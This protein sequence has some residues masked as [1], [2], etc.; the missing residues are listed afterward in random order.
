MDITV[1]ILIIVI[2]VIAYVSW[3][4]DQ[5]RRE[6]YQIWAELHG[7]SYDYGRDRKVYHHYSNFTR[8]QQGSNRY[9]FDI[10]RG[11]LNEYPA[12][13]FNFHYETY[14]NTS[15]GRRTTHHH[16]FGVVLIQ[17]ERFFPKLRIY[18]TNLFGK[19]GSALG[20]GGISFESVEFY[21]KFTVRCHKQKFAYDFCHPRM[22]EYLLT[23]KDTIIEL[24]G[25]ILALFNG[26][27]KMNP[28]EV[29]ECLIKLIQL[30]E[31]MPKYLFRN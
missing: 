27:G 20:F 9:A 14:S 6:K 25:N 8:L 2:A 28:D 12:T 7:W 17:I 16:Y 21:K 24:E 30:R 22:M 10:L 5:K 18:P 23:R 3:L 19:I 4:F 15:K 29:E 26:G 1:V 13:A 31:L 11:M